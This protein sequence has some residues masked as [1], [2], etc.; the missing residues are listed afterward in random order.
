[1]AGG[2]VT[3]TVTNTGKAPYNFIITSLGIDKDVAPGKMISGKGKL[4][5]PGPL[6]FFCKYHTTKGMQGA[7]LIG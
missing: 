7:F 6:P 3:V 5:A 1:V 4:P 2:T